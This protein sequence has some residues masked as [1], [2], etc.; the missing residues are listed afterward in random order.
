MELKCISLVHLQNKVYEFDL[1][2]PFDISDSFKKQEECVHSGSRLR[3]IKNKFNSD[4][5][6]MFLVDDATQDVE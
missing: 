6:K 5:S 1:S 4:G 3:W 2:T